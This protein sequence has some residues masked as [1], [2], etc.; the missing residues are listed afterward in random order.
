MRMNAPHE[1]E[2]IMT[3]GEMGRRTGDAASALRYYEDL[4]L[5]DSV[6]TARPPTPNGSGPPAAGA[7]PSRSVDARSSGSSTS[8]PAASAAVASR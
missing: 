4:G 5:I 8:S 6:R 2:E 7:A 1:P 3:I